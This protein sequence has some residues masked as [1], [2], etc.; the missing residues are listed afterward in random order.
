MTALGIALAAVAGLV[1]GG[2]VYALVPMPDLEPVPAPARTG[3]LTAVVELARSA[4]LAAMLAGVMAF[5]DLSGA[6][7]GALL[8][9]LLVVVPLVLLA[10]SVFHEGASTRRASVHAAD[11]LLKLVALGAIVGAFR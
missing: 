6:A 5:G 4:A 7:D 8:G 10:G 1:I 11:W 2:V 9:L 3:G